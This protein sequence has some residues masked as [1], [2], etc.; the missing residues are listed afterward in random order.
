MISSTCFCCRFLDIRSEK[1][2]LKGKAESRDPFNFPETLASCTNEM[3]S[4][5]LGTEV[6]ALVNK[7]QVIIKLD[8][9]FE[10]LS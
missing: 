6:V 3:T 2:S 9:R 10:S 1:F 7:L 8:Y 5:G 4:T